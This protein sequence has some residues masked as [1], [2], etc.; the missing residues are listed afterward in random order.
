VSA[1]QRAYVEIWV[2]ALCRHTLNLTGEARIAAHGVFGLLNSTP[3][4]RAAR[5]LG[6]RRRPAAPDGDD[7]ADESRTRQLTRAT[8]APRYPRRAT[9]RRATP[10]AVLPP[11]GAVLPPAPCYRTPQE[12]GSGRAKPAWWWSS[13]NQQAGTTCAP[14]GTRFGVDAP[15]AAD[16][17]RHRSSSVRAAAGPAEPAQIGR[18]RSVTT[19][20]D[21]LRRGARRRDSRR[22]RV[23]RPLWVLLTATMPARRPSARRR[24]RSRRPRMRP[25]TP[26]TIADSVPSTLPGR[27]VQLDRRVNRDERPPLDSRPSRG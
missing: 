22:T 19:T 10:G 26:G 3:A 27:H 24:P 18:P 21:V 13:V 4:Q 11:S 8:P 6:A 2:D 7:R 14:A 5:R 9:R 17:G 1:L 15:R 20:T 16:A 23:E 25:P 12:A